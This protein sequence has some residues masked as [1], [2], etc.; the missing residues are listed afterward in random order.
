MNFKEL[1]HAV[2]GA[3]KSK[4]CR[5]GCQAGNSCRSERYSLE[6]KDSQE[7]QFL[8]LQRSQPFF[9]KGLD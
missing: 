5:A 7:A 4:M 6:S 3:G 1:A 8:H 2:V 9:L